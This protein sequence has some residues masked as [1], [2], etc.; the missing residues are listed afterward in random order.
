MILTSDRRNRPAAALHQHAVSLE[1]TQLHQ[2]APAGWSLGYA[3]PSAAGCKLL[4]QPLPPLTAPANETRTGK[5]LSNKVS[6][7]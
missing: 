7:G 4:S 6:H 2:S 5:N 1:D 3:A